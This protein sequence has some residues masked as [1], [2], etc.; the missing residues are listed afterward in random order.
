M[1]RILDRYQPERFDT[2][3]YTPDNIAYWAPIFAM[4]L[5]ARPDHIVLDV[6]CGTGLPASHRE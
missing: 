1:S 5:Q 3:R 6:G 2:E 4:H